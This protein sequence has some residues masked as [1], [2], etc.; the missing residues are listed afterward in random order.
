MD[1]VASQSRPFDAPI[2][3]LLV[4]DHRLIRD[5]IKY[6]LRNAKDLVVVGEASTG[7]QAIAQ[8]RE[9]KPEVV[10]LDIR[11]AGEMDGIQTCTELK[12]ISPGLKVVLIS[13]ECREEHWPR[14]RQCGADGFIQ[15]ESETQDYPGLIRQAFS[16][17]FVLSTTLTRLAFEAL[18][19]VNSNGLLSREEN[20]IMELVEN[21]LSNKQI[22]DDLK[23]SESVVGHK[24]TEIYRKLNA[25]T[26][27]EAAATWRSR[28]QSPKA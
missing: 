11:L 4:D 18:V 28:I 6:Q 22:S 1:T 25:K 13:G 12:R 5:G 17:E 27:K 23:V 26:R 3:I 24:L 9:M 14:V 15:K 19:T 2:R 21:K 20:R 16:G 7:A 10:L 8:T